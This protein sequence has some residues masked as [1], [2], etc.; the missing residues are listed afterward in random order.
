PRCAPTAAP[1]PAPAPPSPPAPGPT[2]RAPT[3]TASPTPT[4][5][6][7]TSAVPCTPTPTG[8]AK[9][10]A[11]DPG[12][13]A[14]SSNSSLVL[15]STQEMHGLNFDGV[16]E[17]PTR[18][19]NGTAGSVRALKVAHDPRVGTP[20]DKDNPGRPQILQHNSNPQRHT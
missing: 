9:R 17:L 10:A 12:Q 14:V 3:A 7:P 5:H 13:P 8:P 2:K 11:L 20:L 15:T 18:N 4:N 1:P 6:R 16:V 19:A